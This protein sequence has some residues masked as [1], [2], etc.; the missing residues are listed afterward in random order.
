MIH[1]L[2]Q[3]FEILNSNRVKFDNPDIS[4]ISTWENHFKFLFGFSIL[5]DV[6]HN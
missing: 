5:I 1:G 6:A 3:K 4:E 2:P